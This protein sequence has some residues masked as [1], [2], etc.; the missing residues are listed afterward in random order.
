M[1]KGSSKSF[2]GKYNCYY[3]IYF[4]K[5][6]YIDAAIKRETQIKSWTRKKKVDLINGANPT[7]EFLNT[8]IMPWPP[9]DDSVHRE[10]L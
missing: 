8:Q 3:L 7:W 4:E 9:Q 10:D 2:T 1:Q 5:A 6:K